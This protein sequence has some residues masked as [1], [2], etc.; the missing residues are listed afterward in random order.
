MKFFDAI[1][2]K[3]VLAA[4]IVAGLATCDTMGVGED[5]EAGVIT[6]EK[7]LSSC[8]CRVDGDIAAPGDG[9]SWDKA[10]KTVSDCVS[11]LPSAGHKD[12]GCEVWVKEGTTDPAFDS[13]KLGPMVLKDRINAFGGFKGNER[14]RNDLARNVLQKMA[15]SDETHM[16]NLSQAVTPAAGT[17]EIPIEQIPQ[18]NLLGTCSCDTGGLSVNSA[19][20]IVTGGNL[21]VSGTATLGAATLN[22]GMSVSGA[23]ST[24][25]YGLSSTD[26]TAL[27]VT[28]VEVD[29]TTYAPL[30]V[31]DSNGSMLIDGNEIDSAT[32][33]LYLNYNSGRSAIFG[34]TTN[35][36][37]FSVRGPKWIDSSTFTMEIK[38]SDNRRMQFDGDEI[39]TIDVSLL[40]NYNSS[41]YIVMAHG[42][43]KV[44]IG[45]IT[46]AYVTHLLTVDGSIKAEEVVIGNVPNSDY[47]FNKSYPLLPLDEVASFVSRNKHLPGVPSA[48]EFMEKEIGVGAIQNTLLQKIE[49]L[50]LYTIEQKK[51][52]DDQNARIRDLEEKLRRLENR[53]H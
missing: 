39:N 5:K 32:E 50:T 11:S 25:S 1:V 37:N 20:A 51:L 14:S 40:L 44:G 33:T 45:N 47:V 2:F 43:G 10:M 24:V 42:G 8:V 27:T 35:S 12:G 31:V 28:G 17:F 4:L 7:A 23:A 41:K 29:D 13:F 52:N 21:S 46:P 18:P 49:E 22:S 26:K 19:N 30:K 16:E 9:S 36:G 38:D 48:K 53:Y 15:Q 34:K 3:A 6:D